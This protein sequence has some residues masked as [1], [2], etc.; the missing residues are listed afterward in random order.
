MLEI[1]DGNSWHVVNSPNSGI[2]TDPALDQLV[3]L[4]SSNKDA[5]SEMIKYF[6]IIAKAESVKSE[7]PAVA[8]VLESIHSD[9][10]ELEVVMKLGKE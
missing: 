4:Y 6:S 7:I 5:F 1:F 3:G 10:K 8:A 2:F 9:V